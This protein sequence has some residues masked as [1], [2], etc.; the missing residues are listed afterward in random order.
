MDIASWFPQGRNDSPGW[1]LDIVS[2]L[3]VIGE[4]LMN[5]H[6]QTVTS[7]WLCLLPRLIP[8]PQ[9]LLKADRPKRLPPVPGITVLG[10]FS[11]TKVDELNFAANL[12]HD[13]GELKNF[14]FQEYTITDMYDRE[15]RTQTRI[16]MDNTDPEKG[17]PSHGHNYKATKLNKQGR[18]EREARMQ[19]RHFSPL[20]ILTIF[21]FLLTVGLFVWAILLRDGVAAL[22]IG[23][24]SL[25]SV[26][27]GIA[28]WWKPKLATRKFATSVPK[29]DIVLKTRGCAFVVVHCDENIARQLYTG[30]DEVKYYVN[31]RTSRVLVGFGTL[32][33]MVAVVLLGNCNFAMQAAIGAS[34]LGLNG[35]YWLTSLLP[36]R[37]F[38]HMAAYKVERDET[39]PH[40]MMNAHEED[41][42]NKVPACYTRTLWYAIHK[43]KGSK[44]IGASNVPETEAWKRWVEDA[45]K[46][47]ND[48]KWPA[49]QKKD[50]Y[51]KAQN[52]DNHE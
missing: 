6:A 43:S 25:T 32:F 13:I 40:H 41:E 17:P 48:E 3:A 47:A 8:A 12:I 35:L 29:G 2:L 11:G 33:L 39:L 22:S 20:S 36:S 1:R 52:H 31:N 23:C 7:S 45:I 4:G 16:K 44:W 14:E 30:T 24:M 9:A 27:T 21:S 51:M 5:D 50:E 26:C 18:H 38:W 34:Y 10:A 42:L 49:V 37:W 15:G 19:A 46:N 28:F